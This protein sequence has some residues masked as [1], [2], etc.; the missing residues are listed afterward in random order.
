MAKLENSKTLEW[1]T[2]K[3]AFVNWTHSTKFAV[4]EEMDLWSSRYDVAYQ[5][6]H[7]SLNQLVAQLPS[8]E[9]NMHFALTWNPQGIHYLQYRIVEWL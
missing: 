5:M 8:V 2:P 6:H 7:H 9:H 4:Y 1:H 3:I